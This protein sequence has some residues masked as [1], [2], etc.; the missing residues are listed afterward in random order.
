VL[1][2]ASSPYQ[3]HGEWQF[4]VS[5]RGLR[6]D[7]H[8][9]LDDRQ[10]EREDL[11]TFVIN[12]QH[13]ADLSA[14]YAFTNRLGIGIGVPF[15]AASWSIPAPT[16]PVPGPRAQQDARGIGDI[17]AIG[18]YWLFDPTRHT[19]GNLAVGIGAKLPTGNYRAQ[20][21]YPDRNGFNNQLRYVDQSIQPGDGGWGLML[22]VQGFRR[23]GRAQ[24]FGSGSYLA[25]PRDTNGTPSL[26]VTRLPPGASP[27][28]SSFDRLV[29]SVPDQ[30]VT[31]LGAAVGLWKS[32]AASASYRV[33]GQRRYD[34]IGRSHGF[35]RPGVAM[36]VEPGISYSSGGQSIAVTLPISF[37]RNRKPD[38]YTG[39]E[40]DATFPRFILM[41]SYGFRFG[42]KK[43]VA[44]PWTTSPSAP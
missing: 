37:Y 5:L 38:P 11:G 29:N 10:V 9:R 33:E 7:T 36:F 8:Y 24:I 12:R 42:A 34:L 26:T 41:A 40:G 35:R 1:G 17:S 28:A 44:P 18:R 32:V 15:T 19:T 6:S 14:S 39:L 23:A 2:A 30:Y 13:A 25:N 22:E 4:N 3:Q 16:T 27:A 20:D 31:R 43:P 21:T